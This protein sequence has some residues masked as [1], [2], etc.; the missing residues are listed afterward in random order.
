M[1]LNLGIVSVSFSIDS[2]QSF[3]PISSSVNMALPR[4]LGLRGALSANAFSSSSLE[5]IE[6]DTLPPSESTLLTLICTES[7]VV[8]ISS[9]EVA[10]PTLSAE[11]CTKPSSSPWKPSPSWLVSNLTKAPKSK[12]LT[13]VPSSILVSSKPFSS[14]AAIVARCAALSPPDLL[15]RSLLLP[16]PP[17][18]CAAAVSASSERIDTATWFFSRSTDTTRTVTVSP[19]LT[20]SSTLDTKSSERRDTCSKASLAYPISRKA[21]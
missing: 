9:T 14:S 19:A 17:P 12:V 8:T 3:A 4:P 20:I 18:P 1:F 15:G 11:M 10:R 13:T 21:P 16:P 7:P 6:S 5:I 2:F